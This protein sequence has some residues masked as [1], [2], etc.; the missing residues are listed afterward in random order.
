MNP[1]R[2]A[3][4]RRTWRRAPAGRSL[5]STPP[6]CRLGLQ[7]IVSCSN[8][9]T[10]VAGIYVTIDQSLPSAVD[11]VCAFDGRFSRSDGLLGWA[12]A[13]FHQH[14]PYFGS[15]SITVAAN[16]ITLRGWQRTWLGVTEAVEVGFVPSQ[17][18]NAARSENS[19]WFELRIG[20]RWRNCQFALADEPSAEALLAALPVNRTPGFDE[21]WAGLQE[22]NR[23]VAAQAGHRWATP[24]LLGVNVAAYVAILVQSG[25]QYIDPEEMS[26]WAN[27]GLLTTQGEWWRLL[28]GAFLH[29]NLAHIVLNMWTLGHAGRLTER[30]Y[31]SLPF[32]GIYLAAG[33][34]GNAA[35]TA[36][37]PA[38]VTAGASGAV[39]GVLGAL[40]AC[41]LRDSDLPRVVV[42]AHRWSTLAFILL[43]LLLGAFS[44]GIDNAAHIGGLVTGL[45]YG[46]L[47][48]RPIDA[49]LRVALSPRQVG[50]ALISFVVVVGL[51]IHFTRSTETTAG[52]PY[53]WVANHSW[54]EPDEIRHFRAA[55]QLDWQLGA[56]KLSPDEFARSIRKELLPFLEQSEARLDREAIEMSSASESAYHA[57]VVR[58][59]QSR[60]VWLEALANANDASTSGD[61]TIADRLKK[62]FDRATA[63]LVVAQVREQF[64]GRP[65]GLRASL[66]DQYWTWKG[67]EPEKC[68]LPPPV[69]RHVASATD[70]RDDGPAIRRDAGC[71]AQRSLW[72]RDFADLERRIAA[73]R[74][75]LAD[76]PD[77][78]STYSGIF[79]GL[80]D[81]I[82]YGQVPH[83]LLL[84][85]F[86]DWRRAYPASAV[87]SLLEA[88]YYH[89]SAWVARG[90]GYAKSVSAQAWQVFHHNVGVS[91]A[92]LED[93]ATYGRE[94]PYWYAKSVSV[95]LDGSDPS[96]AIT[97]V[98]DEG[99]RRFP[100]YHPLYAAMLR[101]L[102]PRWHGSAEA[103]ADFV[104]EVTRA[105]SD[106]LY[107]ELYATYAGLEGDDVD[108]FENERVDWSRIRSGFEQLRAEH[109]AS[110][111]VLNRYAY[112]ACRK[113]DAGT[114]AG[115]RH[116][117]GSRPSSTAWSNKHT[118]ATCDER[119]AGQ[120]P[121]APVDAIAPVDG[122]V[123]REGNIV[124]PADAEWVRRQTAVALQA[125]EPVRA[126]ITRYVELHGRLPTDDTLRDSPEFRFDNPLGA[127][128]EFGLGA[129]I[130]MR[131]SGGPMD[132]HKFS[133]TPYLSADT[134]HWQCA[135]ET[136][137]EEYLGPPCR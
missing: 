115:L 87:P 15:G 29:W 8:T 135:Q 24:A 81:L 106:S 103:V 14:Q 70:A 80:N 2:P 71:A 97:K 125:A 53:A 6:T 12:Q 60:R 63:R 46:W 119:F 90:Q 30:L 86:A 61:A 114:Y 18:R 110:D 88:V 79:G 123:D 56:G 9:T 13:R 101:T 44:P 77:G 112:M 21:Q 121:D 94:H 1:L 133:W 17:F 130:N 47:L 128:V 49:R 27:A 32:L 117:A 93:G 7:P 136:I 76:L 99:A 57:L 108:I 134:V 5:P 85:R 68:V 131:M 132:G 42:K 98:F 40:L 126:A 78:S 10:G 109:A 64:N 58:F 84:D 105:Q 129:S 52:G 67:Q 26:R 22:F 41:M 118:L 19:V 39:F 91:R 51:V 20:R 28:A 54:Y 50:A 111:Y 45:A 122:R 35:S 11:G 66:L 74:A 4:A 104:D 113:G 127:V 69:F 137:P 96:D 124:T 3:G 25:G 83:E 16:V 65:L 75:Q 48:W 23:L 100:D 33:V 36:W 116:A 73:A 82:E 43:S 120:G 89:E 62:D 102:M 95:A 37:N 92:I 59:V 31:G 72:R 34:V 55:N 38:L 107:A